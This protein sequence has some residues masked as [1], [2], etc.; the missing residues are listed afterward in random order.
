MAIHPAIKS[1]LKSYSSLTTPKDEQNALKE[2]IQK[3]CLLGLHRENFFSRAA[4]YGGTALRMI[5][6]LE[7][8]SE[9]LDFC[10]DQPNSDFRWEGYKQALESE[11]RLY[12]FDAR[13]DVK[14]DDSESAISSAFIK[15]S[16]PKGL[17][18]IESKTKTSKYDLIKVRLELDKTNPPGATFEN[19]MITQ[20]EPF[21]I[22]TLDQ[23]SLF[24]GKMHAI[25]AR[26]YASRVKGRDYFD[27][28][29]YISR[30]TKINLTYL[31]N[32]LK[33]SGHLQQSAILTEE[34]LRELYLTKI[35]TVNF[36]Q[37]A[38]DV[39]PYLRAAQIDSLKSWSVKFF[40]AL[41]EQLR[42]SEKNLPA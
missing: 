34:K 25:I 11:L 14:K 35:S 10:L 21:T 1:M 5:Y 4:F 32:K 18:M 7:R 31:S 20:P 24:A 30:G 28:L 3:I 8:F 40:A 15:Q 2:I 27:L 16:T 41:G 26:Q 23:P 42:G 29:F 36:K 37:A 12:G 33:D 17:L 19:K 38:S 22:R 6:G 9:D 13:M 39:S